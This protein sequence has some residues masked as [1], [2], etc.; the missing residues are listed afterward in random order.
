MSPEHKNL[1]MQVDMLNRL[2]DEIRSLDT[3]IMS[4][5]AAIG[6][7]KRTATKMWMGLKFCGLMECCEK[8]SVRLLPLTTECWTN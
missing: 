1:Q 3:N 8:G 7:F 6:D 4:E 5:E 2:R